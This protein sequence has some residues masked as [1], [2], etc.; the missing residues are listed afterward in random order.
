MSTI[1]QAWEHL[2]EKLH[3]TD[4]VR[5]IVTDHERRIQAREAINWKLVLSAFA[6]GALSNLP[7]VQSA[8]DALSS[9][10]GS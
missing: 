8:L 2:S 6:G 10:A 7:F 3:H 5:I 4:P 9:W 1:A